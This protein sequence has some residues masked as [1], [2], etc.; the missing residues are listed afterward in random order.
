VC[1]CDEPNVGDG[2]ILRT[3]HTGTLRLGTKDAWTAPNTGTKEKK[4]VEG[5]V[6]RSD[7]FYVIVFSRNKNKKCF[8]S[9]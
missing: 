6:S 2:G 4:V 9:R 5:E 8:S 7:N 1:V 3:V